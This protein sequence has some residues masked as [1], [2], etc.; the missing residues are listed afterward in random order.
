MNIKIFVKP[1]MRPV[2]LNAGEV[3]RFARGLQ[4]AK[5]HR[6][7]L[8]GGSRNLAVNTQPAWTPACGGHPSY[9]PAISPRM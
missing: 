7:H 3:A 2:D 5:G 8:P 9:N 1:R 4:L 6:P